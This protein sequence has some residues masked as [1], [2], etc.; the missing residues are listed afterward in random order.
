MLW[1]HPDGTFMA[2]YHYNFPVLALPMYQG[3]IH[4][5]SFSRKDG[6]CMIFFIAIEKIL[7]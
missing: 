5:S 1:S 2:A 7:N 3:K 4:Q 6:I